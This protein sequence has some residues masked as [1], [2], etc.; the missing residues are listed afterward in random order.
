MPSQQLAVCGFHFR[1]GGGERTKGFRVGVGRHF[2][3]GERG[4]EGRKL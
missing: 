4:A 1:G 3:D 2:D